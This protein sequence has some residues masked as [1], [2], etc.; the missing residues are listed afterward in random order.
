MYD[1]AGDAYSTATDIAEYLVKRG[2]PF[3]KAH[4]VTGKIV[5]Y[6]IHKGKKFQELTLTELK[7]FSDIISE[8]VYSCLS[9][10]ESIRNKKSS[11]SP[12]V[13]EVKKQI[14]RF[15]KPTGRI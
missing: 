8:D 4:E 11:G 2:M 6:C 9:P 5:S 13:K 3:R 1:T 10:E 15:K 14:K 7:T 12:S